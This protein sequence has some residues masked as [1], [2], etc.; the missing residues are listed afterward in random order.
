MVTILHI[1][2]LILYLVAAGLLAGSLAGARSGA[3]RSGAGVVGA[4]VVAHG[5]ALM[6]FAVV[7]GELPLVGLAPSLS[8]LGFLIGAFLLAAAVLQDARTL[9][10]M[11]APLVA[12]LVGAA[13][14]LGIAPAGE[15]LAFRGPWFYLHAVLAFAGYAGLA[16]A[17]AAGLAYLLQFRELKG[18]RFGRIFRFFPALDTM[19]VV[20]RLGLAIGFPALSLGLGLGWAWT[21][22]FQH[23]LALRDPKVI[24]GALTWLIFVAALAARSSGAGRNRR[25]AVVCVVGFLLVVFTYVALRLSEVGGGG[26]L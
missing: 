4:G 24:W 23:S 25:G 6:A 9:G 17:F 19:D 10:L 15:P 20:G 8:V 18:K 21:I 3:P 16:V 5:A 14:V 2:A 13:L 11:L 12:L 1:L 22:R 26:F 7:F